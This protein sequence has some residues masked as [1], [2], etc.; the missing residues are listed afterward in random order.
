MQVSLY[1]TTLRDGSQGEGISY[2]V[3]DKI[4][5]AHELD[6]FGIHYIEGGWP[7]SN[8]KDM[9]FF[10]KM[11]K[12]PLKKADLVAFSMTRR[13]NTKAENDSN[14][15]SLVKSKAKVITIVG[16][17]WDLHVTD[18]LKT[19]LEEN[20]EMIKDTIEYLTKSGLTVFYD[21]EHFFDAYKTNP[22]YS[23]KCL[24]CAQ[25]SGARA[26]CL[27][28]TNG[29]T[30]TSDIFKTIKEIRPHIKVSLGIHCHNDTGLAIANSIAAVEAGADMVQGTINGYGERCGNADLIPII[31]NLKLKLGINC[32][33]DKNIKDLT[34]ISHFVAEI[35]NMRL[36]N[37]QPYT[38]LSAFAHKGG[39]HINAVMKNQKTYEHINPDSV[40]NRR[41]I[42]VSELAGKTGILLR[43]K[44]LELDLN[45]DNPQ[46]KK[47]LNLVQKLEHEGYHFEAAEASFELL[48]KKALKKYRK[49]FDLEG[50]RVVIEKVSNKKITSEAIIKLKVKGVKEHTAAEG[51][52][53]VNAL[54][55]ALRKALKNFYPT[56]SKMHLSDFKVR[57]LDEKAGTASKV[58]VLIQSQDETD[59][60][61]TIGV[62]GNIIEAS[63]Q[64][65]L[66]SVEYKLLK[67]SLK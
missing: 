37:D 36:R 3:M 5:I 29:G 39:M 32:I 67:D 60:W 51:D 25:E 10:L 17:T 65:L 63:W 44:D 20:I 21:A 1:D 50:F 6:N 22:D 4:K 23:L 47:I 19:T 11:S 27:C 41:R 7:G 14:I 24:L 40:G 34:L 64:A 28:D 38:G 9:E 42:I 49:F 58:R 26:I 45:K 12:K 35:S 8:P 43:A 46:T 48:I 52:G 15:A 31:A 57:V 61:D 33:S 30:M 16:K 56:L 2:S 62:S 54:D 59:T 53:P 55:N 13:L 66:D 18:V